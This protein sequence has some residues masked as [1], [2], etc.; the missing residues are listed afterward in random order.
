MSIGTPGNNN[1]NHTFAAMLARAANVDF[2]NVPYTGGSKVLTDLA[3]NQIDAG[4]LKPLE[5]C[6]RCE[7]NPEGRAAADE[8]PA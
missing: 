5:A 6:E 1:V 4:V 7:Q 3:G 2:V 8:T